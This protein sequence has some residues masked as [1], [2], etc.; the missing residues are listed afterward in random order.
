MS[1]EFHFNKQKY[2]CRYQ[3]KKKREGCPGNKPEKAI[4]SSSS[5]SAKDRGARCAA[6]HGVT[7]SDTAE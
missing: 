5:W 3:K 1:Y 6:V 2:V 7:E 4:K